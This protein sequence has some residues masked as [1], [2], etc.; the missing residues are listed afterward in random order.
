MR[1]YH[2]TYKNK[3]GI[4]T[5]VK[6]FWIEVVDRREKRFRK[7]LQFPAFEGESLSKI[8]G[9]KI[10]KLLDNDALNEK[11]PAVIHWFEDYAPKKVQAKLCDLGLLPERCVEVDRPLIDYMPDFRKAILEESKDSP[12]KKTTTSDTSARTVTARVRK[13]VEGCGF[14]A[15][16]DMDSEKVNGKWRDLKC[17]PIVNEYIESRPD[18]MSQQTAHFYAQAFKRFGQWMFDEGYINRPPK[19]RSVSVAKN[20]GRCFEWHEFTALLEAA[21]T[22]P[23]R[24]GMTGHQRY[25]CYVVAFETGLRRGELR[26]LTVSSIDLKALRIVVKGGPDGATKNKDEAAQYITQETGDLLREYMRGKMP[27]VKL[28][29]IHHRSGQMVRED[30]EAAGIEHENHKGKLTLHSLRHSCGS[31]LLA[32]GVHPKE[33]QEILRHKTFSLTMDRYGHSLD[34][35]K[36][37]AINRLPRFAK[38]KTA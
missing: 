23:D 1:L 10:Q 7:L 9:R 34:G 19:I 20:Y 15:A 24:Y 18:Q 36:R 33:V 21:R 14:K 17:G 35:R 30:C 29:S 5:R 11:D 25:I 13:T 28:F 27:N 2:P 8:L 37:K 16:S 22:G 4:S 26:S 31:H 32:Q 38:E 3:R 12:L 6:K